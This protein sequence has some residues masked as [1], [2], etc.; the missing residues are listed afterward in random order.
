M[1]LRYNDIEEKEILSTSSLEMNHLMS[2]GQRKIKKSQNNKLDNILYFEI[3][4]TQLNSCTF[5]NKSEEEVKANTG[6][7]ERNAEVIMIRVRDLTKVLK[8]QQK[9]SDMMYL[10]AIE[11]NYSHE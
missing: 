8:A 1:T 2:P 9:I 7:N 10:D 3:E 11:A 4:L 5:S 6:S